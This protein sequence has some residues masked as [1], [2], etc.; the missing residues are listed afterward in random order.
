MVV[1]VEGERWIVTLSGVHGDHPPDD[2]AGL[3]EFAESLPIEEV[4]RLVADREVTSDGVQRYPFPASVRRRYWELDRF[5]KGLVVL[6]DA[7]AS[8]NPIY[9]QGMSVATLEALC[10]HH[11]LAEGEPDDLAPRFFDR[12]EDV[13]EN[14]WNVAVGTDFRFDETTGPKP[15]GTDLL[16]RYLSRMTRKAHRDGRVADAYTRVVTMERPPT[17]LLRPRIAWRVLKPEV[18]GP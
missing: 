3:H 11:A 16:N 5:P 9:G 10:L 6:G 7:I 4:A 14:A 17:S 15:V 2:L 8:F 12:A 13:V 1:P 18:T